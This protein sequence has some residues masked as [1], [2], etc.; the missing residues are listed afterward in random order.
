MSL[1]GIM[2]YLL[3]KLII[4]PLVLLLIFLVGVLKSGVKS[5]VKSGAKYSFKSSAK[6]GVKSVVKT[7]PSIGAGVRSSKGVIEDKGPN[8]KG[9]ASGTVKQV[10]SQTVQ[11]ADKLVECLTEDGKGFCFKNRK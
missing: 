1:K 3:S 5:G 9:F 8:I 10:S 7:R 2:Y 4:L 6:S 11:N